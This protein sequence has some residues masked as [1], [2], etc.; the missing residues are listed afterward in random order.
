SLSAQARI[1]PSNKQPYHILQSRNPTLVLSYLLLLLVFDHGFIP[2]GLV[3]ISLS[4]A[5]NHFDL[6]S[7][8]HAGSK[9]GNFDSNSWGH[10]MVSSLE[11]QPIAGGSIPTLS[12][13]SI[14]AAH[15]Q[16]AGCHI[17][18][19]SETACNV[20]S[21]RRYGSYGSRTAGARTRS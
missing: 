6:T 13:G 17:E 11:G 15:F 1:R 10:P 7:S 20:G 9:V 3:F 21:S 5:L 12:L 4:K 18:S 14:I 2:S 16:P 8:G 19:R